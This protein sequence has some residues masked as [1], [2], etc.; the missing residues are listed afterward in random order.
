MTTQ[1]LWKAAMLC[2]FLAQETC[3]LAKS[4]T[5]PQATSMHP[6]LRPIDAD[7]PQA[8]SYEQL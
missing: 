1:A 6:G 8:T 7:N 2:L 5:P 4:T 3:R